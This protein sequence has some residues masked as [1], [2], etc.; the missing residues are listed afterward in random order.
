LTAVCTTRQE[1]A[2]EARQK[3][4]ARRGRVELYQERGLAVLVLVE[5]FNQAAW[6]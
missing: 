4:G 1:S 2:D 5:V 6:R 3:F